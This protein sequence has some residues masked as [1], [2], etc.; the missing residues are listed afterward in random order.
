MDS[1]GWYVFFLCLSIFVGL[2]VFLGILIYIIYNL[3]KKTIVGGLED[4]KIIAE[5]Q[6]KKQEKENKII[7]LIE[8]AISAIVLLIVSSCFVFSLS[9]KAME[10]RIPNGISVPQVVLSESMSY[11]NQKNTYLDKYDLNDQ[12]DRFDLL[13]IHKLPDELELELYDIVV[14]EHESGTLIIHRI[15]G[16]EEPN[17]NHP[18]CRH[19]LLKG[20]ANK[21]NDDFPV[22]YE[23]MRGIY[24]G[25]RIQFVGSFIVFLQSPSGWLCIIFIVFMTFFVPYVDKKIQIEKDKRYKLIT[26][27]DSNKEKVYLLKIKQKNDSP[28]GKHLKFGKIILNI[29]RKK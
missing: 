23:Q 19:F 20:D 4:Q 16:I 5:K 24:K 11:K 15:I 8:K 27:E 7:L 14:Y 6:K 13:L 10:N 22:K 2:I 18:D 17:S 21:S 25:D 28:N 26:G 29:F 9:V 12:F 3:T 1:Y